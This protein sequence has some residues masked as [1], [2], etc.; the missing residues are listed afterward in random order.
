MIHHFSEY[1]STDR[2]VSWL[3]QL[4]HL[5]GGTWKLVVQH[6]KKLMTSLSG[7]LCHAGAG[8]ATGRNR[9]FRIHRLWEKLSRNRR[10]PYAR[11]TIFDFNSKLKNYIRSL[12]SDD[13]VDDPAP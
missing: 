10:T 3:T 8:G 4:K 11:N 9:R 13:I 5:S 1:F 7:V 2:I 6:H 12:A